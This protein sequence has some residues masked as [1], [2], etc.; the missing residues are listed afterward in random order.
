MQATTCTPCIIYMNL[1]VP[2]PGSELK[3]S[4]PQPRPHATA[5]AAVPS[6]LHPR[7]APGLGHL[8]GRHGH[9]LHS[10][11]THTH[12]PEGVAPSLTSPHH[13]APASYTTHTTNT[14]SK[15]P[16]CE[17]CSHTASTTATHSPPHPSTRP[18]PVPRPRP[19][20]AMV[21]GGGGCSC[22]LS[23]RARGAPL[24]ASTPPPPRGPRG[25]KHVVCRGWGQAP[26]SA[27]PGAALTACRAW[28]ARATRS[29][30]APAAMVSWGG[31]SGWA[32][33]RP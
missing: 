22:P 33:A 19:C 20:R 24:P 4:L 1:P 12:T 15:E 2:Q 5:I 6:C 13:T 30:R 8:T 7:P 18:R 31:G 23:G 14:L 11:N 26:G 9:I 16:H 32:G 27:P 25:A 29:A 10:T 28:V 21:G 3:H 17:I